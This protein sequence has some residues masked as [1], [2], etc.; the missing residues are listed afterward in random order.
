M[1]QNDSLAMLITYKKRK[2]MIQK[3]KQTIKNKQGDQPVYQNNFVQYF[4]CIFGF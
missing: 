4:S 3:S 2:E 1:I